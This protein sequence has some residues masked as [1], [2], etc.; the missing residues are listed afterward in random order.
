MD[1]FR[2]L[3]VVHLNNHVLSLLNSETPNH[4]ASRRNAVVPEPVCQR[5]ELR[6]TRTRPILI[7]IALIIRL[8]GA[9][10]S[11]K[12]FEGSGRRNQQT[13]LGSH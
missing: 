2:V 13:A 8:K 5:V 1:A 11:G 9:C 4:T 7:I 12:H 6:G 10:S 3:G